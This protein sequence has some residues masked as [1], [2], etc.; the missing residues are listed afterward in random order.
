MQFLENQGPISCGALRHI[1]SLSLLT[2]WGQR[3]QWRCSGYAIALSRRG[4]C[5]Y[6]RRN[7][8][9][10]K[11]RIL[12]NNLGAKVADTDCIS[13]L[14]NPQVAQQVVHDTRGLLAETCAR[15]ADEEQVAAQKGSHSQSHV[16]SQA[17]H[18]CSAQSQDHD[19]KEIWSFKFLLTLT[20]CARNNEPIHSISYDSTQRGIP[21]PKHLR[22]HPSWLQDGFAY[23]LPWRR[24]NACN[25]SALK[26]WKV[27]WDLCP[28]SLP[29]FF[30]SAA[31]FSEPFKNPLARL[32]FPTIS[33]VSFHLKSKQARA[34][35]LALTPPSFPQ[36][37]AKCI[38]TPLS[39]S[40]KFW[41]SQDQETCTSCRRF[42]TSQHSARR[43]STYR[44]E[45]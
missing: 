44:D 31:T 23:S 41:I 16:V 37:I 4:C 2:K 17:L 10:R 34:N 1:N 26:V 38:P 43:L 25:Q 27:V 5:C 19:G 13:L 6:G 39:K 20:N 29:W 9:S 36:P 42:P 18:D 14:W 24:N 28:N 35:T 33:A 22:C 11:E 15:L 30:I 45:P 12:S 40:G 21:K 32:H 3:M 8:H 7:P